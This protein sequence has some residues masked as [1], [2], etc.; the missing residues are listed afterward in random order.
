MIH[1]V[2]ERSADLKNAGRRGMRDLADLPGKVSA[3]M[4]EPV[5][6]L[7]VGKMFAAAGHYLGVGAGAAVD[8]VVTSGVH[9]MQVSQA[10]LSG[11]DRQVDEQAAQRYA[12]ALKALPAQGARMISDMLAP[13]E[14]DRRVRPRLPYERALLPR[15]SAPASQR[16]AGHV[17]DLPAAVE[18]TEGS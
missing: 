10:Y 12:E 4:P 5:Q 7:G 17:P 18:N 3:A 11:N 9:V 2:Y 13:A 14:N 1:Q 8:T 6:K 16:D 15:A